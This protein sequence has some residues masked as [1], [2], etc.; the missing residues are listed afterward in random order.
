[1]HTLNGKPAFYQEG[2]YICYVNEYTRGLTTA[3]MFKDSLKQIRAE[4]HA[5]AEWQRE[6]GG[7]VSSGYGYI[8]IRV[9]G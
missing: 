6:N 4:Q 8:R 2:T 1:M 7:G 3:N 9:E 5:S